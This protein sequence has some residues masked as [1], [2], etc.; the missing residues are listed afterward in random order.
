MSVLPSTLLE[1]ANIQF[2]NICKVDYCLV[3]LT[4]NI[5]KHSIF[6]ATSELRSFLV[7]QGI[8]DYSSQEKGTEA[9]ISVKTNILTFS[10]TVSTE[11]TMYRSETRG[12]TR[13]WFGSKIFSF[14]KP[15]DIF[16]VIALNNELNIINISLLDVRSF[17][18]TA[19]DNPI[20]NLLR[21]CQNSNQCSLIKSI[22]R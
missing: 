8:H 12:D 3:K 22:L 11:S 13:M 9:K 15:N 10:R 4:S 6:D 20:Q 1:Q 19:I 5:L 21:K 17:W 2:L 16:A 7:R 18:V 14:T